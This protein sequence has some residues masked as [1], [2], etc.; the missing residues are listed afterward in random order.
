MSVNAF[1]LAFSKPADFKDSL[2]LQVTICNYSAYD[3]NTV[4]KPYI[5]TDP[6]GVINETCDIE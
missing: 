1:K 4:G 6:I 5:L 2:D 3:S